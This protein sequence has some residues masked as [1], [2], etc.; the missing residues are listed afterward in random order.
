MNKAKEGAA[1]LEAVLNKDE[2]LKDTN[3]EKR[4]KRYEKEV[5]DLLQNILNEK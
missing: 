4:S 2:Y 1:S 5:E 3:W